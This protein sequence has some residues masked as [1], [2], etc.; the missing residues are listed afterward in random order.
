MYIYTKNI[1]QREEMNKTK[2]IT[3]KKAQRLFIMDT[4]RLSQLNFGL[5]D[6]NKDVIVY[7]MSE[8][9]TFRQGYRQAKSHETITYIKY[10]PL[11]T[12][13]L[14]I[15]YL[16]FSTISD[17]ADSFKLKMNI[18]SKQLHSQSVRATKS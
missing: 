14:M 2:Y 3:F 12:F 9:F 7:S 10:F 15:L 11:C 6:I 13:M 1:R 5:N 18:Y 4:L 8:I 17:S 16:S